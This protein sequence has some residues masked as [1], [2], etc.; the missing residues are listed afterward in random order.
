[1]SLRVSERENMKSFCVC[2]KKKERMYVFVSLREREKNIYKK[3]KRGRDT[4]ERN[5]SICVSEK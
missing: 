2:F 4:E 5:K 1:V 3:S